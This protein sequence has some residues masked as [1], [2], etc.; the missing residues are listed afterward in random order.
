M[1]N[2]KWSKGS[3]I[4]IQFSHLT[5]CGLV[6]RYGDIHLGQHWR[7]EAWRHQAITWTNVKFS[8]RVHLT[9]FWRQMHIT[10][11]P[12]ITKIRLWTDLRFDSNLPGTIEFKPCYL[13]IPIL[14]SCR[15]PQTDRCLWCIWKKIAVILT[16]LPL[17]KMAKIS[18]T[19]WSNA[20]SWMKMF[21]F[22]I[23]FHWNV[24]LGV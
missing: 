15:D 24:F 5:H 23:K 10:T 2:L 18:Q 3:I 6:T 9:I 12:P 11:Q 20:F 16:H 22:Q 1:V 19:T 17:H 7:L 4:L 13:P 14:Q 21:E 8:S